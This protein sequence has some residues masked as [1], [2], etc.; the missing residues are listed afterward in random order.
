[1]VKLVPVVNA[2]DEFDQQRDLQVTPVRRKPHWTV[3]GVGA[4]I[5]LF[6]VISTG[7]HHQWIVFG[8]GVGLL[9]VVAIGMVGIFIESR[10]SESG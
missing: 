4:L 1:M 7:L 9:T 5:I 2:W 10:R 6:A 3:K 8:I